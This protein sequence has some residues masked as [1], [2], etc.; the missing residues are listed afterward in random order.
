MCE[1]FKIY[2]QSFLP[3]LAKGIKKR[4]KNLESMAYTIL[5]LL[6]LWARLAIEEELNWICYDNQKN[7]NL[8]CFQED[9]PEAIYQEYSTIKYDCMQDQEFFHIP[10]ALINSKGKSHCQQINECEELD[11]RSKKNIL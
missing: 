4:I 7:S 1:I 2:I 8:L 11:L 9:T 3:E 10:N 5:Y 6:L